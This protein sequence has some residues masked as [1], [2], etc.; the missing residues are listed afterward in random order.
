[1]LSKKNS[2]YFLLPWLLLLVLNSNSQPKQLRFNR[3]SVENGLPGNNITQIIQDKEGYM[4]IGTDAGL[5]R[6]DGYQVKSYKLGITKSLFI[7]KIYE[8]HS[9]KLWIHSDNKLFQ[10]N[11]SAD[12]FILKKLIP[13][14]ILS[15]QDDNRGN[16]W[17]GCQNDIY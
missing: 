8:D 15:I 1:M 16:I 5:V 17:L 11:R 6:Y 3:L 12:S 2:K 7:N 9:G 14:S 10:Y 13:G 4:W